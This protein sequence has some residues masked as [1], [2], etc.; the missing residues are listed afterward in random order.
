[1]SPLH[2]KTEMRGGL[3]GQ[4]KQQVKPLMFMIQQPQA[5]L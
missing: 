2:R 1:M 3:P 5:E 4:N